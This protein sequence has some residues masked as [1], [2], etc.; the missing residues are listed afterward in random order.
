MAT[1][2]DAWSKEALVESG[3]ICLVDCNGH[4]VQRASSTC[5]LQTFVANVEAQV[6]RLLE[7]NPP[8]ERIR[9]ACR[10]QAL[11][12]LS[13]ALLTRGYMRLADAV[14]LYHCTHVKLMDDHG[15]AEDMRLSPCP[16]LR[17]QLLMLLPII[18]LPY[19]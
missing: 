7:G 17:M 4:I 8:Q 18:K 2:K 5:S 19:I 1:R 3:K 13:R 9:E 15:L 12:R 6:A 14:E 11:L 10:L 16:R